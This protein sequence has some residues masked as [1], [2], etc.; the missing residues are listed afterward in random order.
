MILKQEIQLNLL[1]V[2]M[3]NL[4]SLNSFFK[5]YWTIILHSTRLY[6]IIFMSLTIVHFD[7]LFVLFKRV[8]TF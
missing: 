6:Y 4:L 8:D 3:F 2:T 5:A 1:G 7:F